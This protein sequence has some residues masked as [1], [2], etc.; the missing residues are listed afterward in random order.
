GGESDQ[1]GTGER[2]IR[3]GRSKKNMRPRSSLSWRRFVSVEIDIWF[4]TPSVV[5]ASVST[6]GV[7]FMRQRSAVL[8][9]AAQ[10]RAAARGAPRATTERREWCWNIWASPLSDGPG[11][12]SPRGRGPGR[13]GGVVVAAGVRGVNEA[14]TRGSGARG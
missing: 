2:A 7:G 9:P 8:Q 3:V 14:G 4:L 13:R 12:P 5:R 11:F 10:S 1:Y 6:R